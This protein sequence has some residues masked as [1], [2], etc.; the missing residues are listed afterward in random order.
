MPN[1]SSKIFEGFMKLQNDPKGQ[2]I[3][4]DNV[5]LRGSILKY[6]DWIT[7]IIIE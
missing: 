5:I 4:F 1:R 2:N 3:T 6:S 7:G